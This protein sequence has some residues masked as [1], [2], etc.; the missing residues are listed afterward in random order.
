M[1][2]APSKRDDKYFGIA[3]TTFKSRFK[4]HTRDFRHSKCISSTAFSKY[5]WKLKVEKITRHME[6]NIM[7]IVHEIPKCCIRELF[8]F[9]NSGF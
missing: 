3:E 1:V 7:S 2:S 5:M 6:W 9:E 8:L 4:N